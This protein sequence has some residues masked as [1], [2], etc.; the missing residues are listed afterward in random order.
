VPQHL[1]RLFAA[2]YNASFVI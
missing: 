2:F 1:Q